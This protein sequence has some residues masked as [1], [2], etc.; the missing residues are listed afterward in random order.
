MIVTTRRVRIYSSVLVRIGHQSNREE[1]KDIRIIGDFKTAQ[2][3][4]PPFGRAP[5]S[6]ITKET[7]IREY[8][9]PKV[10]LNS[11]ILLS[12]SYSG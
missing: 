1:K 10:S 3:N 7:C 9:F 2:T 4:A 11:Q 12:F 6:T 5:K 8:L